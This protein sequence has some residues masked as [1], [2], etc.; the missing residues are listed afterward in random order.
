MRFSKLLL[1]AAGRAL[2]LQIAHPSVAAG[3]SEHSTYR[4]RKLDRLLRTLRSTYALIFRVE[5]AS[6]G[7]TRLHA[8]TRAAFPGVHGTVYRLLVIGTRGHVVAVRRM[9]AS[10]RRRSERH[11]TSG[12]AR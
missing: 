4:Q 3:V 5:P 7:Q 10:V 12:A 2:L 9:L 6:S 11:V 8:Q 1:A